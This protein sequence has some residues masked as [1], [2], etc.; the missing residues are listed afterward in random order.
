MIRV[1]YSIGLALATAMA[2]TAPGVAMAEGPPRVSQVVTIETNGETDTLLGEAK[3]NEKIFERLGI[4]AE[5]RYL[6]AT[7]AGP[8]TGT[9]AVVIEYESL[10]ALAAAQEKL[11]A[12]EEWQEYIEKFTGKMTV[13]SNSI[14]IDITP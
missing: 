10:A 9:I 4:K 13:E 3:N 2:I 12:D 1:P 6:Q 14:W 8:S 7:L 5:R 11:A